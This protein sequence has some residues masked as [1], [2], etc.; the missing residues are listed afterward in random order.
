MRT[1]FT[2]IVAICWTLASCNHPQQP[3]IPVPETPKAL[4]G[5]SVLSS[6]VRLSKK[7]DNDLVEDLYKELVEKSPELKELEITIGQLPEKKADSIKSFNEYNQDNNA[8]YGFADRHVVEIRDSIL[9]EKIKALIIKSES[10]YKNKI[11]HHIS[12][13][14]VINAKSTSLEDL[15]LALKITKSIAV[16]QQYQNDHIPG[17]APLQN[18][19][20]QYEKG[21]QKTD[22]LI[23]E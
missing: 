12:L 20:R 3:A 16:M 13:L 1:P 8:Y 22:S 2:L 17:V 11:D 4:Q 14:D 15:H 18:I 7:G 23:K 9:R 5:K 19:I 10:A 21:I 6:D